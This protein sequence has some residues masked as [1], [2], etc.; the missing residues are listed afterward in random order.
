MEPVPL[1]S[2]LSAAETQMQIIYTH[3][4]KKE[5]ENIMIKE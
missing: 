2:V 3:A 5:L 1:S 4:D